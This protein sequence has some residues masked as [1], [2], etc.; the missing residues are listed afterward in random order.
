MINFFKT[1]YKQLCNY[2]LKRC[3]NFV[4]YSLPVTRDT[5]YFYLSEEE[6]YNRIV[7]PLIESKSRDLW[8]L[9]GSPE[10][11]DLDFWL[12]AEKE[13]KDYLGMS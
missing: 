3:S 2:P 10:G 13:V 4:R 12:A 6:H 11:R 8:I 1:L 7:Y 5:K 9:A